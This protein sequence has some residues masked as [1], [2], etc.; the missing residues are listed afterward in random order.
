MRTNNGVFFT[1]GE[2]FIWYKAEKVG[3]ADSVEH[4]TC[5]WTD[6]WTDALSLYLILVF[7]G[8]GVEEGGE[9]SR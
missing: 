7:W 1:K 6:A 8:E 2:F 9:G 4:G 3:K 5:G